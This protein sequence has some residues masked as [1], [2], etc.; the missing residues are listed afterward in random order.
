MVSGFMC[1]DKRALNNLALIY[2]FLKALP[3]KIGMNPLGGPIV[4]RVTKKD[5]PDIGVTGI[6]IIATS[7]IAI[8]TF[9]HG[10]QD[11]RRKPRGINRKTVSPFFTFDIYSCKDFEPDDVVRELEKTFKPKSLE[12]ALVYRLRE[13]EGQIEVEDY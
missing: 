3:E 2:D 6:Q 13:E 10:Q 4:Y 7:H 1:K 9:P 11:G 5:H 12:K 8:H